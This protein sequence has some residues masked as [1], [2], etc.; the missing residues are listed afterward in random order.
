MNAP[1]GLVRHQDAVQAWLLRGDSAVASRIDATPVRDEDRH[2]RLR[3]YR[4]GYALRLVEVLGNDFPVLKALLGED[5]FGRLAARYLDAHPSTQ[6]SVRYFGVHFATWLQAQPDAGAGAVALARFEWAQGEVFDAV[7]AA[8][9]TM[10]DIAAWPMQDW[11][12]LRLSLAPHLRVLALRGNAAAQIGAHAL[13]DAIPACCGGE[14][15]HWLLWRHDFDVHW[16]RLDDDE[17][18]ALRSVADGASFADLCAQLARVHGDAGALRAA[19]LLKR[20]ISDDLV[21]TLHVTPTP[22][23]P[24]NTGDAP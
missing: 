10:A 17:A 8:A 2:A 20:W 12:G 15:T 19:G 11:P 9:V 4:D 14:V 24:S 18:D 22:H 13:G 21:A 3:I 7:D 23:Q 6:P 16:R 5:A 1:A